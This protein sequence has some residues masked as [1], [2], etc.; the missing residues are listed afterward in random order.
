VGESTPEEER[1]SDAIIDVWSNPTS[2]PQERQ[3]IID[4]FIQEQFPQE[5]R[6]SET[7]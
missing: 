4:E 7:D 1:A 5:Q 3:A 6:E 2:T